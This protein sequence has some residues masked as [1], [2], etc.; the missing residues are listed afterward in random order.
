MPYP[1][2]TKIFTVEFSP[3]GDPQY[4]DVPCRWAVAGQDRYLQWSH[5][6]SIWYLHDGTEANQMLTGG[7]GRCDPTGAYVEL[8]NAFENTAV[9]S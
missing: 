5:T 8:Y 1:P 4:F 2:W 9:I 3:G 7:S 6:A